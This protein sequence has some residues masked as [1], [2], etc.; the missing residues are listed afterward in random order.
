MRHGREEGPSPCRR[1]ARRRGPRRRRRSTSSARPVTRGQRPADAG[2]RGLFITGTDTGVGKSVASACLLASMRAAGE[3]VR[4]YKPVLTGLERA[5]HR[6]LA[7]R[8]RAAGAGGRDATAEVAPLRFGPAASPH[9]AAALAGAQLDPRGLLGRA[10]ELGAGHTLLVE[11]VGGLLVPLNESLQRVRPR[12]GPGSGGARG[13]EARPRHDQ[14]H[15]ADARG[16]PPGRARGRGGAAQRLARRALAAGAAPIARRSPRWAAVEVHTLAHL[17]AT[18]SGCAGAAGDTLPWRGWLWA[19]SRAEAS[20]RRPRRSPGARGGE[21]RAADLRQV[22]L[23]G[24]VRRHRVDQLPERPQPYTQIQR[25]RGGSGHVDRVIELDHADR[26]EHP[27]V[28]D[29]VQ[30]PGGRE[31]RPQ[32]PFDAASPARASGRRPAAPATPARPRRRAGCP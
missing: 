12:G 5:R 2:V 17:A 32:G 31:L 16:R 21:H 28:A 15:A 18:R 11:G 30:L 3:P 13:R 8:P 20:A 24:D 26:P 22:L 14:P 9:L 23:A 1:R 6:A 4:A 29:T 19:S 25:G 27:H 7:R 10:R